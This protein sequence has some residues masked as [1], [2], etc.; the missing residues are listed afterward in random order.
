MPISDSSLNKWLLRLE[1]GDDL[2]A[3]RI[4]EVYFD[5]MVRLANDRLQVRH[6]KVVD[7][8]DVALSAFDSFCRGVKR[9]RYPELADKL[10]LWRLLFSI[11]V[12]KLLHVVRDLDRIKRGGKFRELEGLDSSSDSIAAVSL[13]VSRE[14]S[15]EFAAEIADQLDVMM[16][17]LD[18]EELVQIALWKLEGLTNAEI[19]LRYNRTTRTIERKLQLIR[20]IWIRNQFDVE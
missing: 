5:R 8:E 14:P 16:K 19:A 7:A 17:L 2:A 6:R 10:G 15:P 11:T 18:D 3:Q 4:W 9:K 20:K 13:I 1:E 12:H